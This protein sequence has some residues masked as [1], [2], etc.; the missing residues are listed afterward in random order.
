MNDDIAS[1]IEQLV[2]WKYLE[3]SLR[4]F[5]SYKMKQKGLADFM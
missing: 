3:T 1:K 5:E 2:E 4:M